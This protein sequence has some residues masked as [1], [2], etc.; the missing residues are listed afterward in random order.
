[1]GIHTTIQWCDSTVNPTMGCD[2]CELWDGKRHSCY[3]GV[4]HG[5]RGKGNKGYAPS[6]DK[7]TEFPGRCAEAACWSDLSGRARHD[8]PWLDGLPRT[9]F[10][11]DMGDS[12]SKA[13]TFDYL[14]EQVIE[15]ATSPK[16]ARHVWPWL[17]KRPGRM[18]D[19]GAWLSARGIEWP[20]NLWAGT[21]ITDTSSTA[22]VSKLLQVGGPS[23][24]HFLSVEP[25]TEDFDLAA[26]LPRLDWLI[27]GGESGRHPRVFDLGWA[28]RLQKACKLAQVPYFMKQLGAAV[29]DAGRAV[30]LRDSH[31]GD[32]SEWPAD[33]RVR[34][35][36]RVK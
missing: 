13:V 27:Q 23:T 19:F 25:Q 9:I 14:K 24:V 20:A 29:V 18:A 8:K 22:R 3:A 26:Y 28:R 35:L 5:S 7:V 32:W 11:S 34:Q 21:S 6:F 31:G 4:L 10:V 2:G 12:L 15:A 33:L 1:M 17:T 36:P 16:G 30:P